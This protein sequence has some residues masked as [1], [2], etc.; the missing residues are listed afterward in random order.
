MSKQHKLD[1]DQ[2]QSLRD[3]ILDS[4]DEELEMSI[5]EEGLHSERVKYFRDLL[6]LA[7]ISQTV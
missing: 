5:D 1:E 6:R 2:I 7:A 4:L 3:D